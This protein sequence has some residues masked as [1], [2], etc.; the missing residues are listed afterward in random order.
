LSKQLSIH[1]TEDKK[2]PFIKISLYNK[3]K[4]DFVK[5][6]TNSLVYTIEKHV[7]REGK[8]CGKKGEY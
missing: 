5:L 8:R 2:Q 7:R 3:N 6:I 4:Q 1:P